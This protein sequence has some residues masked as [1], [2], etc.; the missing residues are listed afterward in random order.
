MLDVGAEAEVKYVVQRVLVTPR[1]S[2]H[3]VASVPGACAGVVLVDGE[4]AG[5][6][7]KGGR[8]LRGW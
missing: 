5:D 4:R 1:Q 2:A 8:V 3:S 6:V 7:A